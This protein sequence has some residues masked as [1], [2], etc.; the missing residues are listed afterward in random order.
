[1]YNVEYKEA[2]LE[3]SDHAEETKNQYRMYFKKTEPFEA[4]KG[5]DLFDMDFDMLDELFYWVQRKTERSA[6]SFISTIKNYITWAKDNGYGDN[7]LNPIIDTVNTEFVSKYLYKEGIKYYTRK[8]LFKY[9]ENIFNIKD[10]ALVLALFEGISGNKFS[11]IINLRRE[12]LSEKDDKYYASL[13]CDEVDLTNRQLEISKELYEMLIETYN[14]Q[15][16]K[17]EKGKVNR[18]ADG[19]YVFRKNRVGTNSARITY[20]VLQNTFRNVIKAAFDDVQI[21]TTSISNSGVM[22]Y[23][24]E[25]MG[26]DRVLTKEIA[27]KVAEKFDLYG[28]EIKGK[29]YPSFMRFKE[30]I[31]I[32][33]MEE[34]YGHFKLNF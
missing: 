34:E 12:D 32:D 7:P 18:I 3:A 14:T 6:V 11:E 29:K 25:F 22:Y 8:D 20:P 10:K 30:I 4:Q 24:N 21:T 17:S 5:K 27:T 31:D 1:M 28:L 33:Y 26:S 13:L 19:E 15:E 9:F 2:F 16:Y 23:S